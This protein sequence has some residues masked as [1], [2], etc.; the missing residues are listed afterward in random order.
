MPAGVSLYL[1]GGGEINRVKKSV[2]AKNHAVGGRRDQSLTEMYCSRC[3]WRGIDQSRKMI[4]STH[5]CLFVRDRCCLAGRR[6][7]KHCGNRFRT[8]R[9]KDFRS[10]DSSSMCSFSGLVQVVFIIRAYVPSLLH[11]CGN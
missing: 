11:F 6:N 5:S 10:I 9:L 8:G 1:G 3:E 4:S 2:R 7:M